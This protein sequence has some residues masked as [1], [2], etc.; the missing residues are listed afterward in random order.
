[1][2]T[3]LWNINSRIVQTTRYWQL[4]DNQ[5]IEF[6]LGLATGLTSDGHENRRLLSQKIGVDVKY[7]Q[8]VHECQALELQHHTPQNCVADISWTT[9]KELACCILTADCLPMVFGDPNA[10]IILVAHAGWR[11]LA[12]GVVDI[13]VDILRTLLGRQVSLSVW[14][15]PCI[16][17]HYFQVGDEVRQALLDSS[18]KAQEAF[19]IDTQNAG[20]WYADLVQLAIL[21]LHSLG[22]HQIFGHT[23]SQLSTWCSYGNPEKYFSHRRDQATGRMATLAWLPR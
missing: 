22:I 20:K 21:K 18:L 10:K 15:G 6:N 7:L 8:Q 1:M 19:Y 12:G 2:F 14:L 3:G 9:Q 5:S 23:S 16:G 13:A 17:K 11:G 4:N